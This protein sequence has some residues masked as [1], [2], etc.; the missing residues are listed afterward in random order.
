MN[1]AERGPNELPPTPDEMSILLRM[2]AL[3]VSLLSALESSGKVF[4]D[5][6]LISAAE[7][8]ISQKTGARGLRTILEN[9]LLDVMFEL[10]GMSGVEKCVV[11]AGAI[12]GD[13]PVMLVMG[14]GRQTPLMIEVPAQE[15]KS[16]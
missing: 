16:A 4:T 9:T 8:A 12:K 2:F 1:P 11:D 14:D 13:A 6:A 15:R 3:R 10:P 7:N 5:D